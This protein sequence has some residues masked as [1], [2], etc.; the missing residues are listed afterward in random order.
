VEGRAL[1]AIIEHLEA[2][3]RGEIRLL[4]INVPPGFMKSLLVNVF[5]PA[6]EW[7]AGELP[8]LRYVTFSYAAHLTERDNGKFRD[9]LRSRIFREL[10]GHLVSLTEDGKIR[11]ANN[12]TG[13]KFASSVKGVGTGE[14]GDRVILDDPHNVKE[15]ESE[16]VRTETV[17]W[18]REGM[19]NRLNDMQE[20]VIVVIM[21]RVHEEDVSGALIADDLGYVHLMIPMEYDPV[22]HCGTVI[23]WSDWRSKDGELAWPER[24]TR[25]TVDKLK[26]TLGP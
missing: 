18:V 24:F 6:W 11:V 21:Q 1:E 12:H 15:G 3:T 7:S 22:R 16:A 14:R 19:S 10:W 2:V 26:R 5:W 9:L 25:D 13:W 23:G 4:L 17:R 20:G 8:G